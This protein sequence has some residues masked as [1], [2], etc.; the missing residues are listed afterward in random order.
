M[1]GASSL[2]PLVDTFGR[3]H[4]AMRIS[5]TDRCNLRCTYCMPA[6]GAQFAPRNEVLTFEEIARIAR[7]LSARCGIDRLRLTGGEPLV[8]SDIAKLVAML[9]A[10]P[11]VRSV[12]MTTNGVLLND[13]LAKQLVDAGL[14]GINVSLDSLDPER[15]ATVTRR[16]DLERTLSGIEAAIHSGIAKVKINTLAMKGLTDDELIQLV[17]FAIRHDVELRLIEFMPLDADAAW[18]DDAVMSGDVILAILR[19]HFVE[20]RPIGRPNPSSPAER[21]HVSGGSVQ[22]VVGIIRSVT[23]PFC[24]HCDRLRLTATGAIR[25]CLFSDDEV[26]LRDAMRSGCN[27][28]DIVSLVR[29]SVTAK[30]RAHGISDDG[31]VPPRRA[32]YQIGG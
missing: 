19:K 30:H 32:M 9:T 3:V 22:G 23:Q 24:Q 14:S 31:F 15:F 16:R 13:V 28:D 6:T 27:D 20:V 1:T 12:A 8:R 21:F 11:T 2:R 7:V 10:F 29:Q 4:R 26:S 25:N 18:R 5:V 17:A